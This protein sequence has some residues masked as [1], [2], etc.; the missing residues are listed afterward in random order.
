MC[1]HV[2]V[3]TLVIADDFGVLG[4][5]AVCLRFMYMYLSQSVLVNNAL[6]YVIF[7]MLSLYHG[8]II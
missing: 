4:L 5:R 6:T 3:Y 7:S 8:E 2:S 1:G